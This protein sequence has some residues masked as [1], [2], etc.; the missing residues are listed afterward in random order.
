MKKLHL[1]CYLQYTYTL[2]LTVHI[3][4]TTYS[5]YV[6]CYLQY[7]YT[8]LLTVHMYLATYSTHVTCYLQY[9]CTLLL[10]EHMYLSTYS[11]HVPCHLQY[12]CTLLLTGSVWKVKLT[13]Q[14]CSI[15]GADSRQIPLELKTGR[16]SY[17]AEHKGQVSNVFT[18]LIC[19]R[20]ISTA[21]PLLLIDL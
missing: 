2:L 10:T 12:T 18:H 20:F 7:T 11:S 19:S 13:W 16:P 6:P 1:P 3:Y 21:F 17:S 15:N 4:L 5:T 9:T 8:L 14:E